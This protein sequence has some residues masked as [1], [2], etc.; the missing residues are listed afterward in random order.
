MEAWIKDLYSF[1]AGLWRQFRNEHL[2]AFLLQKK[3]FRLW[4][5]I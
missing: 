3:C 2:A 1:C 4:V 5:S